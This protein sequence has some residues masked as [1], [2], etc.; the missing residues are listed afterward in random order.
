MSLDYFLVTIWFTFL[1]IPA[2]ILS[3]LG[4]DPEKMNIIPFIL[5]WILIF[6]V[7]FLF[8]KMIFWLAKYAYRHLIYVSIR[9]LIN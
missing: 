5:I 2:R 6:T 8:A 9:K 4:I 3:E 7:I 1:A